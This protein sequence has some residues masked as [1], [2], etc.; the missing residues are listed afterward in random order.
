MSLDLKAIFNQFPEAVRN[1][2]GS[3]GLSPG[4][5]ETRGMAHQM[6]GLPPDENWEDYSEYER[7]KG[8]LEKMLPGGPTLDLAVSYL[9]DVTSV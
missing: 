7:V 3:E 5:L 8:N 1:Y 2:L 6:V 9:R 4:S